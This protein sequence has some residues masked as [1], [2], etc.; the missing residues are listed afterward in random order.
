MNRIQKT[1]KLSR[2]KHTAQQLPWD[3]RELGLRAA[4]DTV[5][6]AVAHANYLAEGIANGELPA[7]TV[8]TLT[9]E[10][11]EAETQIW[12]LP[13]LLAESSR[14][15]REPAPG[16]MVEGWLFKKSSSRL[17]L[18][19]WNKRW[20][21]MD[22]EGIYYFRSSAEMKKANGYQSSPALHMSAGV[23]MLSK[24]FA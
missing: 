4:L 12:A 2:E 1:Q 6:E 19:Q 8:N 13:T 11:L 20:F 10:V 5:G 7:P 15:Q 3:A 18:Q 14:Y 17:S 21:M 16:V 9:L 23:V 22:K 24:I